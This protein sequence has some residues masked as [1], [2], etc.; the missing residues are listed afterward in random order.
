MDV[1][2]GAGGVAE[3][4]GGAAASEV[5]RL[6]ARYLPAELGE[7]V[8]CEGE[9]VAAHEEVGVADGAELVFGV[10]VAE[11][12]EALERECLYAGG[13]PCAQHG[14]DLVD[15]AEVE[16]PGGGGGVIAAAD[17]FGFEG[18]HA[19]SSAEEGEETFFAATHGGVD[20]G[21]GPAE[22]CAELR[23]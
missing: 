22:R 16:A 10:H 12:A 8:E 13:L 11:E 2:A 18:E 1:D 4:H 21:V 5:E 3:V 20:D 19:V 23:P 6:V 17:D 7:G 15:E 14:C 9:L